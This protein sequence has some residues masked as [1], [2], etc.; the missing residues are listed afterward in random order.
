MRKD[1]FDSQMRPTGC[2]LPLYS[3][4][5]S[6]WPPRLMPHWV[7]GNGLTPR[8]LCRGSTTQENL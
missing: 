2:L 8:K 4:P 5:Y 3:V 7:G 6:R 1:V